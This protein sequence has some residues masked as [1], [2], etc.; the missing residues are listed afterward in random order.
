MK[1]T[2]LLVIGILLVLSINT[3]IAQ[4]VTP[5]NSIEKEEKEYKGETYIINRIPHNSLRASGDNQLITSTSIANKERGEMEGHSAAGG[6]YN[7]KETTPLEN[8]IKKAI[9]K[10]KIAF[11]ALNDKNNMVIIFNYNI[12]T[13]K[14]INVHFMLHSN[15]TLSSDTDSETEITIKDIGK[16]ESLFK[17]Y[18]FD[19]P[20]DCVNR[21]TGDIYGNWARVFWFSKL[22]EE[23]KE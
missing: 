16:L 8:V 15:T 13:G 11:L 7:L 12:K 6:C 17:E 18:Y 4:I 23:E 19:V 3:G 20:E 1:T 22:A 21:E 2:H 9:S 14:V 10:E 5:D